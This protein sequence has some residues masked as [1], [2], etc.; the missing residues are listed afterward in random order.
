MRLTAT[1]PNT[2]IVPPHI[3]DRIEQ[4]GVQQ[5]KKAGLPTGGGDCFPEVPASKDPSGVDVI[6]S[7]VKLPPSKKRTEKPLNL[8]GFDPGCF[9]HLPSKGDP[10]G[11]EIVVTGVVLPN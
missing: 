9:P 3:L 7:D 5:P 11:L 6:F 2:G 1:A 8:M 10:S 4:G